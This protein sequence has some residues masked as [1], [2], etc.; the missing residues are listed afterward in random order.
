MVPTPPGT[1][2]LDAET[3]MSC[4]LFVSVPFTV[5]VVIIVLD[6]V[7]EK[8]LFCDG[9]LACEAEFILFN[10]VRSFWPHWQLSYKSFPEGSPAGLCSLYS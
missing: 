4:F 1:A 3:S 10:D 2:K 9:T 5:D 7:G 6:A 8:M